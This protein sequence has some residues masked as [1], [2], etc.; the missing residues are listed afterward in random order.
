MEK[1]LIIDSYSLA[2]RIYYAVKTTM[3][4]PNGQDTKIIHG[5]LTSILKYIDE[6]NI[7]I[8]IAAFDPRGKSFRHDIY[9]KYKGTRQKMDDTIHEQLDSLKSILPL[10]GVTVIEKPGYEADD[11]IGSISQKES[12]IGNKVF[13]LSGDRDLFALVNDNCYQIYSSPSKK[14]TNELY[15][16]E[17]VKN[18]FGVY[19]ELVTTFKALVGDSSDNIPGVRGIGEKT[20]IQLIDSYGE[21]DNI[22]LNI[23][24]MEGKVRP[25]IIKNLLEDKDSAYLS[26][27]L[28]TIDTKISELEYNKNNFDPNLHREKLY[29]ILSEYGLT[30]I[31]N[32]LG[33]NKTNSETILEKNVSF[34]ELKKVVAKKDM[35]YEVAFTIGEKNLYVAFPDEDVIYITNDN[36]DASLSDINEGAQRLLTYDI[37]QFLNKIPFK[38]DGRDFFDAKLAAYV[39]D[40]TQRLE[41]QEL[42]SK[43]TNYNIDINEYIDAKD[44]AG[45]KLKKADIEILK[46]EDILKYGAFF[47]AKAHDKLNKIILEYDLFQLFYE[48]EMPLAFVLHEMSEKG[49]RVD[50][51]I[52]EQYGLELSQRVDDLEKEIKELAGEDFKVNSPKELGIILFEKLRLPFGKKNKTGWSTSVDVL[53][54]LRNEHEIIEKILEYRQVSKLNSTYISGLIDCIAEDGRIH[55]KFRQTITATGRL[56]ST[57]PNL[58]NLPIKTDIGK[59]LRKAFIPQDGYTFVDADYSQIELRILAHLSEDDSMIDDFKNKADI[60][61]STASRV[62]GV[63][64]ENVTPSQRRGAKAINF[65]L[66]YGMGSF[67]LSQ[68]LGISK[69]EADEYIQSYFDHYSKIQNYLKEQVKLAREQGYVSTIYNRRRY[70]PEINSNNFMVR[71][72]A[73]RIAMNTT[74]QGSASDI[75]KIAMN[76]VYHRLKHDKLDA[77]IILQIHD[78]L[79]IEAK[80]EIAEKVA[81]ILKK[82]MESAAKLLVDL[83]VEVDTGKSMYELK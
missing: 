43:Y 62:F 9:D 20:A 6:Y 76:N 4:G 68:D 75:M 60:H 31:V 56:S 26:Y 81:K 16:A 49:I 41:S 1:I 65:G 34:E 74:I 54:K 18:G 11:V 33:I 77:N 37:K 72:G 73:E 59:N 5:Y 45:K 22:F 71:S 14:V 42:L 21:L 50:K 8:V 67:S 48:I 15:D 12:N 3:T 80:D 63:D 78:E 52:L 66:I 2:N 70:I 39:I 36:I 79:L 25:A 51:K 24:D 29:D 46:N 55:T 35:P 30:K 19:P 64:I 38:R 28:A 47:A 23:D 83:D 40:S 10:M 82:E 27:K 17:S 53:E 58:Q 61:S 44:G 7:D 13:I 32:K 69:K 57:E